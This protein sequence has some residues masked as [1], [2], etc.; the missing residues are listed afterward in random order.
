MLYDDDLEP[1]DSA[2]DG[3]HTE[4]SGSGRKIRCRTRRGI[5]SPWHFAPMIL[6]LA[7]AT[8]FLHIKA[9]PSVH[10]DDDSEDETYPC[11]HCGVGLF[12]KDDRRHHH[13]KC[14]Q[15]LI[16]AKTKADSDQDGRAATA[17]DRQSTS[18]RRRRGRRTKIQSD[19]RRTNGASGTTTKSESADT[20]AAPSPRTPQN[21]NT[22][23]RSDQRALAGQSASSHDSDS[24]CD[25]GGLSDC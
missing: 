19:L 23:T 13:D 21:F 9:L 11:K 1:D 12:T 10:F 15:T 25:D 7:D 24:A 6:V 22:S 16:K 8:V 5:T 3:S 18:G 4:A 14:R 2:S 20:P 17:A